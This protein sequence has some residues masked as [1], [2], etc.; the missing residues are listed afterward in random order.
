[1]LSIH[2]LAYL[3]DPQHTDY[4]SKEAAHG[5]LSSGKGRA[6][7]SINMIHETSL[8]ITLMILVTISGQEIAHL[9]HWAAG[10]AVTLTACLSVVLAARAA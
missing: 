1:M 4:P 10:V 9:V 7:S 6:E 3:G 5:L 8:G 2:Q